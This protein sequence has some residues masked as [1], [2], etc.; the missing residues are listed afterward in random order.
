MQCIERERFGFD[1]IK[2]DERALS[3][4]SDFSSQYLDWG[5]GAAVETRNFVSLPL[6][7]Q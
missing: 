2:V 5:G 4:T 6:G 3:G 7:V 1:P